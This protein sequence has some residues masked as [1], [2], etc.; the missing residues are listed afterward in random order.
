M[1]A[2]YCILLTLE[3]S[4]VKFTVVIYRGIFITLAPVH[5]VR[6]KKPSIG[7]RSSLLVQVIGDEAKK[8][9][10]IDPRTKKSKTVEYEI[11]FCHNNSVFPYF[12]KSLKHQRNVEQKCPSCFQSGSNVIKLF[13]AVIYEFS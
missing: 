5:Q 11:Y 13:T 8:F 1:A 4:R 10:I 9:Y 2:I 6:L 12:H 3:K 7:K